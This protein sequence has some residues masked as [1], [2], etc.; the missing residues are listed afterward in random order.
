M[1]WLCVA[2]KGLGMT[3]VLQQFIEEHVSKHG[4]IA[5]KPKSTRT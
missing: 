4:A 3:T 2:A 1:R 5:S